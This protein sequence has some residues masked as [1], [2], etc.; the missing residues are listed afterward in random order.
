MET[1]IQEDGVDKS[2]EAIYEIAFA[3][4]DG[5][6]G[7]VFRFINSKVQKVFEA[8]HDTIAGD[9]YTKFADAMGT[10]KSNKN[11]QHFDNYDDFKEAVK[12]HIGDKTLIGF[13][14]ESFDDVYLE[15]LL[16]E[17]D[18]KTFDVRNALK[19]EGTLVGTQSAT[20]QAVIALNKLRSMDMNK[21]TDP[22]FAKDTVDGIMNNL[23][24][25][26]NALADVETLSDIIKNMDERTNTIKGAIPILIADAMTP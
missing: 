19:S 8:H 16:G 24:N 14:N 6:N 2:G 10:T 1:F 22:L 5:K 4:G 21:A 20:Y 11:E 7:K 25:A 3:D 18:N 12:K 17:F 15:A 26:H 23:Q 13:N 9:T